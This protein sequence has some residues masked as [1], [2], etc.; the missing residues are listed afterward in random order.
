MK[1]VRSQRNQQP[2]LGT[3]AHVAH[4]PMKDANEMVLEDRG[5]ELKKAVLAAEKFMPTTLVSAVDI[6]DDILEAP[7]YGLTYPWPTLTHLTYG[8]KQ[9]YSS[10]SQLAQVLVRLIGLHK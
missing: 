7:T 9:D 1:Q 8:I 4:L 6:L 2:V 5:K 3:K 10:V